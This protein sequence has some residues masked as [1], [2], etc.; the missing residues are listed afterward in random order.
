MS[1]PLQATAHYL[2]AETRGKRIRSTSGKVKA[3]ENVSRSV[4]AICRINI[5]SR[6]CY[7]YDNCL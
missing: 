7:M 3:K 6:V 2:Q 5:M 4:S 1:A